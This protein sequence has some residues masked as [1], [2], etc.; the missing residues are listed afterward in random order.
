MK[1]IAITLNLA[2]LML[3]LST[4][5]AGQHL[6]LFLLAGIIPG[7]NYVVSPI[8]MLAAMSTAFTTVILYLIAWPHIKPIFIDALDA[9]AR[10]H[11]TTRRN[12]PA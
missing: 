9:S 1:Y 5:N 11:K 7:T 2:S 3:I 12:H 4:L 8:D 6:T 10:E